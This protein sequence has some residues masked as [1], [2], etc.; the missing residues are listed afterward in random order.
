MIR[1][2]FTLLVTAAVVLA[3]C[4]SS[5]GSAAPGPALTDPDAAELAQQAPDSFKVLFETSKGSFTVLAYR[6]WAPLGVDRFHYLAKHEYYNGVKFFRVLPNFVVQFGIHGSPAVSAAWRGRN[7]GDDPVKGSNQRGTISYAM[8]GPGT[9]TVQLFINKVDNS[10][11]DASGFAPI[12]RVIS[13]ME[14]VEQ[15]Y[16]GYGE[17]APRGNG[18]MQDMI[19]AQGNAYL[20]RQFPLLDSIV[21]AR[22]VQE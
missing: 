19:Q 7:I 17:G 11:L 10:R 15:I 22:I 21:R 8:G 16:G 2:R 20:T 12:A 14:V 18:P 13:G 9:R 3:A 4:S 1:N 6:A 5:S